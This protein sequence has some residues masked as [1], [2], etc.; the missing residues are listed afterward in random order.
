MS[1]AELVVKKGGSIILPAACPDGIGS[2]LFFEWMDTAECPEDVME[3]FKR[4]AYNVGTSKAWMYSRCILRAELILISDCLDEKTLKRMFTRKAPDLDSAVQMALE[5]Q[6]RYAKILVL[7][8]AADMIPV[9]S[10]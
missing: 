4:E 2:E 3:R 5:K 1:T 6:G 9:R 10:N 7:R 8:N